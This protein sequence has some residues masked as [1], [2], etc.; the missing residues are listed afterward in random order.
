MKKILCILL[1]I[2]CVTACTPVETT[3]KEAIEDNDVE[4][5]VT[6]NEQE[7]D[8]TENQEEINEINNFQTP[9]GGSCGMNGGGG[10]GCGGGR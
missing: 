5:S 2:I 6:D 3:E 4:V 9:P 7:L 10:C 8:E 1:L